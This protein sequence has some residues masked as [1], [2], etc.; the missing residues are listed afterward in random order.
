MAGK[1]FV[2]YR[3]GDDPGFTQALYQRLEDEFT[4]DDLFMDVE[5][6]IK[7]G[8]DFVTV[9]NTQ[10]AAADVV[11]AV[12]G[13]R[14]SEL[15]AA[16]ANDPDD[17]VA[18]EIKAA[19]GNNKRVI[20]VLVGGASMPRTDLL[21]EA[22]KPLARRNAVGLRPER[23]KADCQGLI[24]A[25]KE[26]LAA[27][28]TERAARSEA[29]RA[30][31]EAARLEAEAQA[32]ARAQAAEERR[33]TQAAEGLSEEAI[34]T[35]QELANWEF[36]KDRSDVQDLRDHLARF[37]GGTTERYALSKLEHLVWNTL[38]STPD[39]TQLRVYLDEFPKGANAAQAQSRIAALEKETAEERAA[40]QGR[41]Q[42]TAEWGA[43]AASTDRAVIEAFLKQW[44]QGQHADAARARI[45]EL[46]RGSGRLRRGLLLGA[47]ATAAV[48]A[49]IIGGWLAYPRVRL[50][51]IF[52]DVSLSA[53]T[54]YAEDA[55]KPGG[56]FKEC[57]NCPEMVVVPAGTYV[58][59]ANDGED[60][61]KPPHT[62]AIRHAFAVGKFEVTFDEW[63][64]CVAHG[65][66]KQEAND[67]GWGRGRRPVINVNWDDAEQYET[68][69]S[70][71]TGKSYRLLSEAE[72]EY[73]ARAGTTTKYFWG[74]DIGKDNAN[75]DGCGG[76]WDAKQTAPVGSFKSN[77]F[78]LYDMAGN[79]FQW[80][81]D[82]WH[83][84]YNGA[85][86]DGS[87]WTAAN[88]GK[89]VFRGGS[90][91]SD[92]VYLGVAYRGWRFF[93]VGDY[94]GGFRLARTL[95]LPQLSS[96]TEK[97]VRDVATCTIASQPR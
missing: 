23:F 97:I 31:A 93:N 71:L 19:L 64:A 79:V 69:I 17:F 43:V 47:G 32:A 25:L 21:P 16:R 40:E 28:E 85:P 35:A 53:L 36:V 86:A 6:H 29:E 26:Q 62:V 95:T 81:E 94:M 63:D 41:V 42:E 68:W 3:R 65:G 54:A 20:P 56:T 50:H 24:T 78:G 49:L 92:P 90:W 27:A 5:G 13:P 74:D 83:E 87:A 33:R 75:C 77:S 18:I 60:N 89:P 84:N 55:L 57:V 30:A 88:C 80:V 11:L 45:R 12:I 1:I 8:D 39:L 4:A 91:K 44:P 38:G 37:P 61:E 76:Q 82:C 66:C 14:W 9:L 58:M 15:L 7:P 72:W 67:N 22:I 70:K 52:W 10:V 48:F 59:G 2:N 73:A 46:Q 34:R 96:R 51:P